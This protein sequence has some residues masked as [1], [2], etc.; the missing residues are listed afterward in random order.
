MQLH[1]GSGG[2][3]S[4]GKT[5]WIPNDYQKKV[6]DQMVPQYGNYLNQSQT[7]LGNASNMYNGLATTNVD[8]G[9]IL[10][11]ANGYNNVAANGFQNLA[12][13][14][15]GG[16]TQ[17]E[18]NALN[19]VLQNSLGTQINNLGNRGVLNTSVTNNAMN[20]ITKQ[21]ASTAAGDY[22]NAIQN[23]GN[24]YSNLIQTGAQNIANAQ[25]AQNSAQ[26]AASNLLTD[27]LSAFNAGSGILGTNSG[28]ATTSNSGSGNSFLNTALAA[29]VGALAC[30]TEDTQITTPYGEKAIKN[31]EVGDKVMSYEDG[32]LVEREVT[33]VQKPI[34]KNIIEVVA[35]DKEGNNHFVETTA[36]QPFLSADGDYV[37]VEDLTIGQE[38]ANVG[39]VKAVMSLGKDFV[40]DIK[41]AGRNN[42]LANGFVAY[43][44]LV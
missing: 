29:G 40:Y 32:E 33:E 39:K 17:N 19:T 4:S 36:T 9:S 2:S 8:Y 11:N 1:G 22:N 28:S 42:Y 18:T 27:S 34:K 13:G 12:N 38:L 37:L 20:D 41:V 10:D 44:K 16:F 43:G 24:M 25:N 5:K 31:I 14:N 26:L 7:L 6:L 21:A 23:S 15:V 35:E 30:F 3:S